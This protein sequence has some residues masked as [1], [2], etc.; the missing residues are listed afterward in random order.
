MNHL[1][2][3]ETLMTALVSL[4]R[5]GVVSAVGPDPGEDSLLHWM[6][7]QRDLHG[8]ALLFRISDTKK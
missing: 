6:Q 1:L 4:W 8:I 7:L 5:P 2:P 3:S